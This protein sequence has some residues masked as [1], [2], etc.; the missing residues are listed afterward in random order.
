MKNE[1]VISVREKLPELFFIR[2]CLYVSRTEKKKAVI[3]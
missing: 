3:E 2:R 1:V